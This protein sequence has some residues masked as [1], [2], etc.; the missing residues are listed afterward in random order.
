MSVQVQNFMGNKFL[1]FEWENFTSYMLGNPTLI[2]VELGCG[3]LYLL[4]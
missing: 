1:S 2:G 4:A 3:P